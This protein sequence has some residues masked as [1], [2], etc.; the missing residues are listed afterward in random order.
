MTTYST[1]TD[2]QIDQ[3]SP[4]TQPLMT[5]LRDNPIAIA[6]GSSGSPSVLP[7][8]AVNSTAGAVGT[9]AFLHRESTTVTTAGT[10]YPASELWFAAGVGFN[11]A[12]VAF[13]SELYQTTEAARTTAGTWRAMTTSG[14][15]QRTTGLFIRIA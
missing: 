2:G 9:Y 11:T 7:N 8:I 14:V 13:G 3:D 12:P 10:T 15:T 4:I 6:E 1:I 5:A